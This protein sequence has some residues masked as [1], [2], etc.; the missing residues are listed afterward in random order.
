MSNLLLR[1]LDCKKKTSASPNR[2]DIP[3]IGKTGCSRYHRKRREIDGQKE[4]GRMQ[5]FMK[6]EDKSLIPWNSSLC[7][8][9]QGK[10][11]HFAIK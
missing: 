1:I 7:R 11:S 9:D 2:R 4:G 10:L 8:G 6:M 5:C 3:L